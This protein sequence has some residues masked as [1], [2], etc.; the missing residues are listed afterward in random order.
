MLFLDGLLDLLLGLWGALGPLLGVLG[1]VLLTLLLAGGLSFARGFGGA[2]GKTLG[3][4]LAERLLGKAPDEDKRRALALRRAVSEAVRERP[5][6]ARCREYPLPGGGRLQV[7]WNEASGRRWLRNTGRR[8]LRVYRG[9]GAFFG[10]APGQVV[11]WSLEEPPVV[12]DPA[13]GAIVFPRRR[14]R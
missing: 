5:Q 6:R 10:L 14:R 1:S 2:F 3:Q 13:T 12:Q 11:A 4:G 7:C 8:P 9:P